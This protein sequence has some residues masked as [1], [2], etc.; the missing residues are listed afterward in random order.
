M[1][2]PPPARHSRRPAR[3]HRVAVGVTAALVAV[4]LFAASGAFAVYQHLNHN[5]DTATDVDKYLG[6]A[7][8]TTTATA[9]AD[10][11]V[12]GYE[13]RPVNILV[14]GIDSRDGKNSEFGYVPGMRS[15]S[16][17]LVH[18]PADR[19]RV[20]VVSVPRDSLL[21]RPECTHDDGS[22]SPAV[23]SAMVNESFEVGG[24]KDGNLT[25]AAACTRKTFEAAS[26]V[27]TDEHVVIK[28]VGVRNVINTLGGVP[29]CVPVKMDSKKSGLHVLPGKQVFDGQTSIQ[30]LR[31]RTGVGGDL[32]IGSDL[33]RLDRQ[34]EF[35]QAVADKVHSENL[36]GKP[37]TLLK[38][39]D[40]ATKAISVSP[41][42][43]DLRSI[44]GLAATLRGIDG[45]D[46]EAVT[47]PTASVPHTGGRVAWTSA[48]DD[49]WQRIADDRP[50][51]DPAPKPTSASG[52]PTHAAKPR[53]TTSAGVCG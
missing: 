41:G 43:G 3:S 39:L 2:T 23:A 10:P 14:M 4:P 6:T 52:A 29:F 34:H 28:M 48:A 31:T 1:S 51:V 13:G 8:P 40:Q 50:L 38:V 16:M 5:L 26:G 53:A 25:T 46:I 22:T 20:D 30:W 18:L 9:T 11:L 12:D 36:L 44:A 32:W 49:V 47:V 15:D 7:R 19:S 21:P 33:K 27:R 35:L 45:G 24:G 17:F 42:L 37:T